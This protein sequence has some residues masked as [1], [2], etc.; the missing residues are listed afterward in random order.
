MIIK[1]RENPQDDTDFYKELED[2]FIKDTSRYYSIKGKEFIKNYTCE[3][4]LLKVESIIEEE[5]DRTERYL[6]ESSFDKYI[7]VV[8]DELLVKNMNV[9][10]HKNTGLDHILTNH[11]VRDIKLLYKLYSPLQECLRDVAQQFKVFISLKGNEIVDALDESVG[12]FDKNI[13]IGKILDS[14]FVSDIIMF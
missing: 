1:F 11:I 10:L 14:R 4:Y 3:E 7:A 13:L 12:S 5:K 8:Q 2:L 6:K 9:I